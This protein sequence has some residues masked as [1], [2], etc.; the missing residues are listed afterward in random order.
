MLRRADDLI[1]SGDLSSA[2]LLLRRVAEAGDARA[3]FTLAGTYDPNVLNVLGLQDGAPD[4]ALARLWCERAAQLG[5]G[6]APHRS[7]EVELPGQNPNR[8]MTGA[9]STI[10][11]VQPPAPAGPTEP[12]EPPGTLEGAVVPSI[13]TA[14]STATDA[15]KSGDVAG[16]AQNGPAPSLPR[17][18][19]EVAEVTADTGVAIDRPDVKTTAPHARFAVKHPRWE[20]SALIGHAPDKLKE[21]EGVKPPGQ[22]QNRDMAGALSV[23]CQT[24]GPAGGGHWAWRLIDGRKCWYKGA[25]GMDKSLLHWPPLEGAV[26]PSIALA[27]S[28]ATG[29]A[30]RGDVAG[31]T[32][33]APTPSLPGSGVAVA[34]VTADTRAAI[35][36]GVKPQNQNRDMAGALSVTC[37]T[38]GPAGGGHWAWRLV[39]GRQCW[40]KGAAGMDKSLLH[41][42]PLEHVPQY[43]MLATRRNTRGLARA[44]EAAYFMDRARAR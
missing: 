34:K 5:S 24:S 17:P 15:A 36:W 2:R 11:T 8:D 26:V 41:W 12:E 31:N 10:A 37:Q 42:P 28:A 7:E 20:P 16:D 27:P 14:P 21:S 38:S 13:A 43:Y 22:N 1:K 18:D 44:N 6:D 33:N 9:I 29:A 25:A 35:D 32:E 3:A 39:D 30:A 40:Y 4:I 23:T 19:V